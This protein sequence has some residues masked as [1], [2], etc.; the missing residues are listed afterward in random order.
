M[1]WGKSLL[2][3][4][5][6][7]VLITSL[8]VK[9]ILNCA[10]LN[11]ELG[12]EVGDEIVWKKEDYGNES[13]LS[14]RYYRHRISAI[15]D[16]DEDTWINGTEEISSELTDPIS[17]ASELDMIT[18]QLNGTQ[19]SRI[20]K[21]F[22]LLGGGTYPK[23]APY[24]AYLPTGSKMGKQAEKIVD[25]HVSEDNGTLISKESIL[26][27]YGIE[28][29]YSTNAGNES[30]QY[31]IKIVHNNQGLLE[32]YETRTEC[33]DSCTR[34]PPYYISLKT[35]YTLEFIND[36][37]YRD[38]IPGFPVQLLITFTLFGVVLTIFRNSSIT[39]GS[40]NGD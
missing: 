32:R 21:V 5:L 34:G 20:A 38:T 8:F 19:Y 28:F 13:L 25:S 31:H 9:P 40:K 36:K 18:W 16:Y 12:V 14:I 35:L 6:F 3:V 39:L 2:L 1:K 7:L 4:Y 30:I 26:R 11:L 27:D 24:T 22:D 23:L 15:T 33:A 10:A 17:S 37:P 29:L